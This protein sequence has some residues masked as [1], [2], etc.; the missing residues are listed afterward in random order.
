[1]IPLVRPYI[2]LR[3]VQN[4]IEALKSGVLV[5][6]EWLERFKGSLKE[7]LGEDQ[8]YIALINSGTSAL[9]IALKVLGIGKGDE[10]IVP[11]LTFPSP[12]H[13]V[14]L[15]NGTV[16]LCDVD[17]ETWNLDTGLLEGMV[18]L[19]TKAIIGIDQ[20]GNPCDWDK[21][22]EVSKRYGL[23]VIEDAAC[24]LGSE[25]K[26][27]KCGLWGDISI[28]SFHPRKIITTGE[29]GAIIT[30]DSSIYE[31]ASL[32]ID[33]GLKKG[34][35]LEPGFNLR[36]GELNGAIGVAQLQ[37]LKEFVEER[38]RKAFYYKKL[39]REELG[40]E[41][42]KEVEGGISNFQTFGL[43]LPENVNR[44]KFISYLRG[45]GI[46]ASILSYNLGQLQSLKGN[47]LLKVEL[48]VT[49]KLVQR[50]VALPLYYGIKDR[51][52]EFIVDN[53]KKYYF[54]R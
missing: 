32:L 49:E 28:Y 3:E 6:G 12:A 11:A 31:K 24:A 4:I 47:S 23:Y 53:I 38:R 7:F 48:K 27:K 54:G 20:F 8:L 26:G 19:K 52:I 50:G 16:V 21:V 41:T 14:L 37:K 30:K 15:N 39:I 33:N 22:L 9:Y 25:Y 43:I 36:M 13:A 17:P 51:E 2:D 5:K 34:E 44:E 29:G 42:Q 40:W 46:E 35:F 1:M 45:K 10:V 18:S